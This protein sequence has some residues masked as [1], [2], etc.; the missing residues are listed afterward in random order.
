MATAKREVRTQ[1][2]SRKLCEKTHALIKDGMPVMVAIAKTGV[3]Q[4]SYH[5]WRKKRF[6]PINLSNGGKIGKKVNKRKYE[7][8]EI[9]A[10]AQ[11]S[12]RLVM[13]M[14]SPEDIS[15]ALAGGLGGAL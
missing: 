2:E 3:S 6:G 1:A 15:A 8:I 5:N 11:N 4:S 7:R 9:P 12:G 10:K 13:L 14:G